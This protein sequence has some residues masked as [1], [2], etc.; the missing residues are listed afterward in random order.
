ME[1]P[2]E[3]KAIIEKRIE[4]IRLSEMQNISAGITEKYKAVN[5]GAELVSTPEEADVYAAVRMPATFGA[6]SAAIE[7]TLQRYDFQ[8]ESLI[9]VGAGTGAATFAAAQYFSMNKITCIERTGV[10]RDTGIALMEEY[11]INPAPE[12]VEADI[13]HATCNMTADMVISSYMFNEFD[14]P[15]VIKVAESL[16]N[17]TN[18]VLL[19]VEPGTVKGYNILMNIRNVL[20]QK[21]AHI[22]AP[23]IKENDCPMKEDDWCHFTIRVPRSRLHRQIKK[24]DVPYEDEKFSYIAFVK[25]DVEK[26]GVRV[27]RHPIVT[28]NMVRHT[29]CTGTEILHKEYSKRDKELFKTARKAQAGDCIE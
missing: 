15:S 18:Q 12:W 22:A 13:T 26:H 14:S 6:I 25:S 24:A 29:V 28:K 7:Y 27:L 19:I 21:G 8:C 23:C 1:L 5:K 2:I 11:G 3:L 4:G 16:W 17:M 20:L 10:M 9:D